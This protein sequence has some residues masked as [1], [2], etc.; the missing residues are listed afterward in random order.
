[1]PTRS[2]KIKY[3]LIIVRKAKTIFIRNAYRN[4]DKEFPANLLP[5]TVRLCG[6]ITDEMLR[7]P[8]FLFQSKKALRFSM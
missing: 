3:S 5:A 6:G 1:M 7:I 2:K 8:K 4:R